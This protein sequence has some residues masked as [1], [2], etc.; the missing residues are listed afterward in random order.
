MP[1]EARDSTFVIFKQVRFIFVNPQS[2]LDPRPLFL[3]IVQ[4]RLSVHK[5]RLAP[6]FCHGGFVVPF[7]IFLLDS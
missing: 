7:A 6:V 3:P 4:T 1:V 2:N 5:W